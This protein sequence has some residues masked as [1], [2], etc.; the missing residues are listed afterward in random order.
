[1][2]AEDSVR[3]WS[4][5]IRQIEVLEP[6]LTE[7]HWDVHYWDDVAG[8]VVEQVGERPSHT[9][10]SEALRAALRVAFPATALESD[11]GLYRDNLDRRLDRIVDLALQTR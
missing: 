7:S 11:N 4:E 3:R 1:M 2:T 5:A 9:A 6:W 10:A 8:I